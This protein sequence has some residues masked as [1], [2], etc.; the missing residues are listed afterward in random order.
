V[1]TLEAVIARESVLRVLA[2]EARLV[3][4]NQGWSMLPMTRAMITALAVDGGAKLD[5]FW[6]APPGFREVLA[7]CSAH[8]PLAYVEAEFFGG[9]GSQAAQVWDGGTSVLGP[10]LMDDAEGPPPGGTPISRALRHLGVVAD[11]TDEFTAA[12]LDRQRE[13]DDWL[14]PPRYRPRAHGPV[15]TDPDDA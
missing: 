4:L 1:Y 15:Y 9:V 10:L 11:G 3:Q 2:A 12:G 7:A 6:K 14:N 5:G 13:T 8:G